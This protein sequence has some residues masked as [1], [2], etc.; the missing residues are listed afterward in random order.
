MDVIKVECDPD[1]ATHAVSSD[2][3]TVKQNVKEEP[4][5]VPVS[6]FSQ[7]REVRDVTLPL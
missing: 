3:E 7:E 1:I 4:Q 2:G 6:N 5:E